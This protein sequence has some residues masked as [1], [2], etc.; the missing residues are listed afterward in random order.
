MFTVATYYTWVNKQDFK[1][2]DNSFTTDRRT[3]VLMMAAH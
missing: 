2:E 1:Y 3:G